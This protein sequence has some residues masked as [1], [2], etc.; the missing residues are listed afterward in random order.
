MQLVLQPFEDGTHGKYVVYD[1]T[2]VRMYVRTKEYLLEHPEIDGVE[3]DGSIN[4]YG[5]LQHFLET[6]LTEIALFD[7]PY[8]VKFEIAKDIGNMEYIRVEATGKGSWN[9]DI[10]KLVQQQDGVLQFPPFVTAL[11]YAPFP[12]K[13][14]DFKVKVADLRGMCST[15]PI[16]TFA[17]LSCL[18]EFYTPYVNVIPY[19]CCS[20]CKALHKV[21]VYFDPFVPDGKKQYLLGGQAFSG[22]DNLTEVVLPSETKGFQVGVFTGCKSLMHLDMPEMLTYISDECFFNSGLCSFHAP[23]NLQSIG[24]RAFLS[25]HKLSDVQLNDTLKSIGNE[26]FRMCRQLDSVVLPPDLT[27]IGNNAFDEHTIVYYPKGTKTDRLLLNMVRD[28]AI[29]MDYPIK[30]V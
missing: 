30:A 10:V 17:G 8:P 20:D 25:T 28:R 4:T 16:Q 15:L 29:E 24:K 23:S 7:K 3:P 26:A 27:S 2:F 19:R 22:C 11:H 18:E 1:T 12:K 5:T 14:S 6:K 21:E 13:H 9:K